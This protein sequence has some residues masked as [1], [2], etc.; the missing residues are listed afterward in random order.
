MKI[1]LMSDTHN[2][3]DEKACNY[4]EQC[5]EIWHAGDIGSLALADDIAKIKPLRAV[6]GN[7][8]GN[9]VRAVYPKNLF[10]ECYSQRV[11]ITHIGGYPPKYNLETKELIEEY[12]P[13]LFICGHSHILKVMPDANKKMLHMNPGACG[14]HGFHLINTLLQFEINE[15]KIFNL[16]VVELGKRG[17]L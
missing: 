10:F 7:I 5:D 2:M 17:R 13:T 6:Y 3:L 14:H 1:V 8:D 12:K 15:Q 11:F 4:L 9:D 16:Q